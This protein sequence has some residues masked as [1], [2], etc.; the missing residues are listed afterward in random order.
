MTETKIKFYDAGIESMRDATQNDW[1][2]LWSR[3]IA[4][5]K[6]ISDAREILGA[7]DHGSLPNDWTL[8]QVAEARMDDIIKLTWQVRDTCKRAE[9]AET[10]LKAI[11]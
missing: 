8:S 4:K 9:K 7:G 6:E 11:S 3:V 1:D 5:N 2:L 10:E